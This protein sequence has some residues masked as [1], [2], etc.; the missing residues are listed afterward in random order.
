MN[1]WPSS[2][3]QGHPFPPH[4]LEEGEDNP[5]LRIYDQ[6][7]PRAARARQFVIDSYEHRDR[8]SGV[9]LVD[10]EVRDAFW[11]P[12]TE[13]QLGDSTNWNQQGW[14]SQK[15]F[16]DY[17]HSLWEVSVDA[18]DVSVRNG[19]DL[20]RKPPAAG[21]SKIWP[22][23]FDDGQCIIAS[24]VVKDDGDYWKSRLSVGAVA[25]RG[26]EPMDDAS[27]NVVMHRR[28]EGVTFAK[29]IGEMHEFRIKWIRE[30][31]N[32]I[33]TTCGMETGSELHTLCT[34][35]PNSS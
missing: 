16:S 14:A 19:D 28:H 17:I 5:Y 30:L 20:V 10:A 27:V 23:V 1:G 3:G 15:D 9:H 31:T 21:S 12:L 11:C 35:L 13:A 33:R 8:W 25:F 32:F 18:C 34:A 29:T 24:G 2:F 26:R 6:P 4:Q 7:I 22:R